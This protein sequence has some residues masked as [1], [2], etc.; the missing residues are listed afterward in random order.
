MHLT[1]VVPR[2]TWASPAE[3]DHNA[4]GNEHTGGN[5]SGTSEEDALTGSLATHGASSVR[6]G[7]EGPH[8]QAEVYV[9][10][11]AF[12]PAFLSSL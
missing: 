8:M 7:E 5:S 6:R 2:T 1:N 11:E 9:D 4:P 12:T 10:S 3:I